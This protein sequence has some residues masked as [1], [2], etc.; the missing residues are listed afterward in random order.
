MPDVVPSIESARVFPE[1]T[2]R[3]GELFIIIGCQNRGPL[4]HDHEI[5]QEP[6]LL[7]RGREQQDV[8][9]GIL[10]QYEILFILQSPRHLVLQVERE[11]L[12]TPDIDQNHGVAVPLQVNNA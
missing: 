7:I 3:L 5:G 11:N 8:I 2:E 1:Q 6:Q 12:T 9:L 10:S 4:L